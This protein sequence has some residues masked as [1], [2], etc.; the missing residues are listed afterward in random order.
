M[1]KLLRRWRYALI[2]SAL[3]LLPMACLW[4]AALH[5][6]LG[7]DP[8]EALV[9]ETGLWALRILLA[10]FALPVFVQLTHWPLWHRIRRPLGLLGFFYATIHIVFYYVFITFSDWQFFVEELFKRPY[11]YVGMA[12]W[13]GLLAL[14]VT[15]NM[16][17][18][19]FLKRRWKQL[20]RA[21]YLIIPLVIWHAVW[22]S[23]LDWRHPMAYGVIFVVL[24]FLKWRLRHSSRA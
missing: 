20:H 14:A 15:S 16:Y 12:A 17:S 9:H 2:I 5:G 3:G 10:T 18:M 8:Q 1:Y 23:K 6:R 13:L 11:I 24:W 19:H 7:A 21:I 22:Q 4:Y